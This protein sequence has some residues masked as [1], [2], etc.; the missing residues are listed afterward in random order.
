[1]TVGY[2]FSG[3][4]GHLPLLAV[5]IVGFV[6]VGTRRDRLGPR[7]MLFARLG[8]G[9]LMLGS[10]LQFAWTMLIP[11]L[12]SSLNYSATRYG[13]VFG[14]IGLVTSL[15]SAAGVGLL[16]AAVV[17]RGSAP[18]FA[19]PVAGG[20]PFA[21]PPPPGGQG[22]GGA[23]SPGDQPYGNSPPSG[24]PHGNFRPGGQPFGAG[25]RPADSPFAG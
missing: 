12:Y 20:Q 19:G 7:S 4:L 5:L 9:A 2:L 14:L 10:L 8:L 24:Q 11:M 23:P 6:L 17:T 3:M 15:I 18:G 21:G 13:I 25:D 22:F 1:M 16:I